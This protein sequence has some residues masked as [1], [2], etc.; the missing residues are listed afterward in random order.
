MRLN[1]IFSLENIERCR[2][3]E[4]V[5][6]TVRDEFG[7]LHNIIVATVMYKDSIHLNFLN[8]FHVEFA[9]DSLTKAYQEKCDVEDVVRRLRKYIETEWMKRIYKENI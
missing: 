9:R 4:E 2:E 8:D 3:D 1:D 5:T 7:K 6:R